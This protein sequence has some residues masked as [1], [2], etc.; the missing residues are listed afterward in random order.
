[1][2]HFNKSLARW[3]RLSLDS[4]LVSLVLL[5]NALTA[6]PRLHELLH[7]DA[8]QSAHQCAATMFAHGHVDAA[9]VEVMLN[10][11]LLAAEFIPA[12]HISVFSLAAENLPPGRA[13]P[14]A[15]CNS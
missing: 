4:L 12:S 1:L 2:P 6:S 13:P 9:D 7:A 10:V 11:P 14:V 3:S 5:L 15:S 8:S